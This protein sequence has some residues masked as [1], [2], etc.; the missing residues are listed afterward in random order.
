MGVL[1]LLLLVAVVV[2]AVVVAA[3][4]SA[5]ITVADV[6]VSCVSFVRVCF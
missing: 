3:D 6:L 1:L 5:P 4:A 2:A